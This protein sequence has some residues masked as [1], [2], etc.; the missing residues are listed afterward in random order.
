MQGLQVFAGADDAWGGF[1]ARYVER[2][3]DEFGKLG[4]WVWGIEGGH[5]EGRKVFLECHDRHRA[6]LM[7]RQLRTSSC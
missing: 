6:K 5:G 2:V 4:I 3:R 7:D 1:A